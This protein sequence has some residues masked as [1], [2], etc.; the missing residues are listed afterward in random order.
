MSDPLRNFEMCLRYLPSE[1]AYLTNDGDVVWASDSFLR[2]VAGIAVPLSDDQRQKLLGSKLYDLISTHP[3]VSKKDAEAFRDR[4]CRVFFHKHERDDSNVVES[5]LRVIAVTDDDDVRIGTLCRIELQHDTGRPSRADY[6]NDLPLGVFEHWMSTSETATNSVFFSRLGY[7]ADY[8]ENQ[9]LSVAELWASLIH[10]DDLERL[11]LA[12][13]AAPHAVKADY[14]VRYSDDSYRWMRNESKVHTAKLDGSAENVVGIQYNIDQEV[15]ARQ[16]LEEALKHCYTLIDSVDSGL[17]ATDRH[18]VVSSVNNAACTLIGLDRDDVVGK[19]VSSLLMPVGDEADLF[20]SLLQRMERTIPDLEVHTAGGGHLHIA[21]VVEPYKSAGTLAGMTVTFRDVAE[22]AR[23]LAQQG[24]VERLRTLGELASGIAHDFNN[25]LSAIKLALS[26]VRED[27]G[28]SNLQPET[29]RALEA[30]GGASSQAAT[31]VEQLMG[32]RSDDSLPTEAVDMEQAISD[33]LEVARV[34]TGDHSTIALDLGA[35]HHLVKGSSDDLCTALL[36]LCINAARA[37]SHGGNIEISTRNVQ[38][39]GS[40]SEVQASLLN[41]GR[42]LQVDVSDDGVGIPPAD[43][44]RVFEPFFTT[45]EDGTG[46]GLAR[47]ESTV[48]N[49]G[50]SVKVLDRPG[51]GT[52]FRIMLPVGDVVAHDRPAPSPSGSQHVD[53]SRHVL[54]VE[55]DP[56]LLELAQLTLESIGYSVTSIG[57]GDTALELILAEGSSFSVV[58][59]DMKMPGLHGDEVLAGMRGEYPDLPVVIVGGHLL[60]NDEKELLNAGASYVMRKPYTMDSLR[61][62]IERVLDS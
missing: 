51:P 23:R 27:P 12:R 39:T 40:D 6:A 53:G 56:L 52:T 26:R 34:V 4:P 16:E 54:L 18:G 30:I 55:D 2:S 35:E 47:V 3:A 14:R 49:H 38:L 59:L 58:L 44:E 13:V 29:Q 60:P 9:D 20:L 10:P 8:P 42:Y 61:D 11:D 24:R 7:P 31:V 1:I 57:R 36:N 43:R 62:A 32:F 5:V 25:S 17:I 22:D 28:L 46:L 41:P 48:L 45:E 50:G 15:V 19:P 21:V 37:V 33:L